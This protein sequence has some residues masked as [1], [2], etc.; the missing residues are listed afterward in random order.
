[1]QDITAVSALSLFET[2]KAQ[3]QSFVAN[4]ISAINEGSVD[5]I[6]LHLQ[7]K[8]TEQLL[9]DL[10]DN[11]VYKSTLLSE[12]EKYGKTFERYNSKFAIK[13]A[14]TR[15]DYSKCE[16][17][18]LSDL[19]AQLDEIAAKVKERQKMLQNLPESGLVDPENGNMIY[20]PVKTST[21]TVTVTL[22]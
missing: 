20:R 10:K 19:Q 17:V 7:V 6:K 8:C 16:D 22:S 5:P 21:T 3:R 13:E 1:M 9:S 4:V 18:V 14:G 2:N 11:E 12:A 15:Y